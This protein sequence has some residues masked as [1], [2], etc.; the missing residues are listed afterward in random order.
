MSY[1]LGIL[2]LKLDTGPQEFASQEC[3]AKVAMH[4]Y[5]CI[6]QNSFPELAID[7]QHYRSQGQQTKTSHCVK[8]LRVW[9]GT[10]G[11]PSPHH[12]EGMRRCECDRGE[13]FSSGCREP[14][15]KA[16]WKRGT[17]KMHFE[18]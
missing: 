16:S 7:C 11:L 3:A 2:L 13:T 6:L 5:S 1:A 12:M 8:E 10:Q 17:H 9:A 14:S 4:S 18:K 15:G